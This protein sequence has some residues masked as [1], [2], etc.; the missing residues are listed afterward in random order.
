[1]CNNVQQCATTNATMCATQNLPKHFH[2][3][4]R[5]LFVLRTLWLQNSFLPPAKHWLHL[6]VARNCTTSRQQYVV[7]FVSCL[8][9]VLHLHFVSCLALVLHLLCTC[10]ALALSELPCNDSLAGDAPLP[11]GLALCGRHFFWWFF[12]M[13]ALAREG[14][15]TFGSKRHHVHCSILQNIITWNNCAPC[16]PLG[17][18]TPLHVRPTTCGTL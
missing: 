1:M 11:L 7:H 5:R 3:L 15:Y 13:A 2:L 14:R 4:S 6:I 17:R 8:A 9:L 10:L 12:S 18:F 16:G